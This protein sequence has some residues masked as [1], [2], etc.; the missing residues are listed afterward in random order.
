MAFAGYDAALIGRSVSTHFRQQR[1]LAKRQT[2]RHPKA[3]GDARGCS[4]LFNIQFLLNLSQGPFVCLIT[5]GTFKTEVYLS[6]VRL[7]MIIQWH[8][9]PNRR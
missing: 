1:T 7:A 8:E 2:Q 4:Y 3:A 6:I 5:Q 9:Q